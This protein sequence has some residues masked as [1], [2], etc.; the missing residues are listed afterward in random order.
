VVNIERKIIIDKNSPYQDD[1]H[2]ALFIEYF[3]NTQFKCLE[4]L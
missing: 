4:S 3:I 1:G 2:M